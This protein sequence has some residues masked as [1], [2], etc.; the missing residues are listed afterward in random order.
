[1]EKLSARL[2]CFDEDGKEQIIKY[3][4][5]CITKFFQSNVRS[6]RKTLQ[7]HGVNKDHIDDL[8]TLRMLSYGLIT[9]ED[10]SKMIHNNN[11]KVG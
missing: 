4:D 1:M 7:K 2:D 5:K 10:A 6:H 9:K 3:L 8:C 11:V